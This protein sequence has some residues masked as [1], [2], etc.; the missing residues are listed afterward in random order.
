MYEM[1]QPHVGR[2]AK[3]W[4]SIRGRCERGGGWDTVSLY[5]IRRA[6]RPRAGYQ[7]GVG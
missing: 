4:N 7:Q 3:L 2:S 6:S 1:I 5:R